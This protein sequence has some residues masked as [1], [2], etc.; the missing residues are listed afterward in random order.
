MVVRNHLNAHE[1]RDI[2][3]RRIGDFARLF[4]TCGL[5]YG[6][7]LHLAIA[8]KVNGRIV[9]AESVSPARIAIF[10]FTNVV[11]WFACRSFTTS[12]PYSWPTIFSWMMTSQ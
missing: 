7:W 8:R 3:H 4:T 9:I 1:R 6:V 12:R 2:H 5:L 11:T 10:F